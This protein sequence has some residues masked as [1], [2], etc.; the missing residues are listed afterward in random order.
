[1]LLAVPSGR[2]ASGSCASRE[3]ARRGRHGAVA[4]RRDHE[5]GMLLENQLGAPFLVDDLHEMMAMALEQRADFIDRRPV[6]GVFVVKE[7]DPHMYLST[8]SFKFRAGLPKPSAKAGGRFFALSNGHAD[9]RLER[10]RRLQPRH[11]CAR[12]GG[13]RVRRC[14]HRRAGRRALLG[15]TR[16]HA[17]APAVVPADDD[18]ESHRLSRR[19]HAS[20]LRGARRPSM[21]QGRSRA[22]G[23]QHRP[24]SRQLD[25]ALGDARGGQAGG[26]PGDAWDCAE[27]AGGSRARLRAVQAVDPSRA[28]DAAG[29]AARCRS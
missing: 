3:H 4:A 2:I 17:F 22:V 13:H 18:S 26:A 9:P 12:R 6:A 8:M 24:Q 11:P 16:H 21:G 1:M 5:I 29:G 14:A 23:T 19:R 25:L 28:R 27:R 7:C 20:R 10:R 15:G